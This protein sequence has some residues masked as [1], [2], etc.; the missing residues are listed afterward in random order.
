[1]SMPV[2]IIP[3]CFKLCLNTYTRN[4]ESQTLQ[5]LELIRSDSEKLSRMIENTAS[6]SFVN[7]EGIGGHLKESGTY[8]MS[9]MY[10][11]SSSFHCY[12]P[13]STN[14]AALFRRA[15]VVP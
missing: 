12:K 10:S 5:S 14:P 9:L 13:V 2:S 15:V 8:E 7:V 1:M 6:A 11:E 4:D 3:H